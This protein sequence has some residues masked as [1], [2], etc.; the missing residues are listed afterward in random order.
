MGRF[1][2]AARDSKG[3][4]QRG[5]IEA[6]SSGVAVA[7]LR[8]EGLFVTTIAEQAARAAAFGAAR[9]VAAGARINARTLSVFCQ[10][11]FTL[12]RAGVPVV[13]ALT[14]VAGQAE[15]PSFR[16]TL[17]RVRAQVE[18]G[19]SLS[20]ALGRFGKTFPPLLVRLVEA[21]ELSGTL[22]QVFDRMQ[23]H[24]A[25]EHELRQKIVG[26]LTYPL[27]ILCLAV[28]VVA[29]MLL[30]VLPNFVEMF[31][32]MSIALPL[33]TQILL[34]VS[35]AVRRLWYLTVLVLVGA[36][37]G[38]GTY[39]RTESGRWAR[40]EFVLRLPVVGRLVRQIE[41][42]RF[43]RT[44]GTLLAGGIPAVQ[45]LQMVSHVVGNQV[46]TKA[47]D[48]AVEGIRN[49]GQMAD[50]L[51][52]TR[53]FPSM[54]TNMVEVGEAT[55]NIDEILG[56]VAAYYDRETENTVKTLTTLMEPL[57]IILVGSVVAL[58]IASVML[59][60]FSMLGNISM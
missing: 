25:K 26:A 31:A 39:L 10:Q 38:I 41:M 19:E 8:A 42:A 6:D 27:V 7:R 32:G 60:M 37:V 29:A 57:I 22:E 3:K 56:N 48:R 33:P 47:V 14:I 15:K 58:I 53:V 34:G 36:Y 30:F 13:R 17:D 16:V 28:L 21:G 50:S 5:D 2:Y 52:R 24:Y 51:A 12:L 46:I 59:P 55:G 9:P 43:G 4:I 54:L 45:A 44:L 49:G 40:D 20:T 18:A 23:D 11:M 1:V 35:A